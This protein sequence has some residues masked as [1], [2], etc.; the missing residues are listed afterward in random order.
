MY[1]ATAHKAYLLI[2]LQLDFAKTDVLLRG[3]Q[4]SPEFLNTHD[5]ISIADAITV[6]K[7]LNQHSHTPI[8]PALLGNH[9]GVA[10]HGPVGYAAI[11]APSIGKV[12]STFLKWYQV[13]AQI[14]SWKIDESDDYI[15]IEVI[16]TTQDEEFANF[17]FEAF[18]RAF[19]VTI[20]LLIGHPA[21]SELTLYF[22]QS[23]SS[24]SDLMRSE[25]DAS[26]IFAYPKN[27]LRLSKALWYQPSPLYDEESH[28]YNLLK[29]KQLLTSMHE[30]SRIDLKITHKLQQHF[31]MALL[32]DSGVIQAP[33]LA[34][35]G[36]ELNITERTLIRKLSELQNSFRHL[37]ESERYSYAKKLLRDARYPIFRIAECLGYQESANFCRAFKKWSGMTPN[38]YRRKPIAGE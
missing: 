22:K 14:Y 6:V 17:F 12:L 3:T 13:R 10:S 8:W 37:L 35:I 20:A 2:A 38:Q 29:C 19:E 30:E 32:L 16:D 26:L 7:N 25:Y 33:T 36:G 23:E 11:S 18:M 27:M 34:Q 1:E 28:Q 31:D 15:D 21:T 9:L 4:L 5:M 24:R